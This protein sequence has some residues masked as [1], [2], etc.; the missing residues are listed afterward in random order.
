[1][2]DAFV[3][4]RSDT[5]TMPTQ[6]MLEAMVSAPLG[7]DVLGDEPTVIALQEKVA[8]LLGKEASCFVPSGTMANLTAIKSLTQ[9]GDEIIAEAGSH[10]F[11]YESGAFAAVAG[12]S[13]NLIPG[14]RGMITPEEIEQH[15]RPRNVHFPPSRLLCLENTHNAG[16]GAVWP[17]DK[18]KAVT[19]KARELGL[20][21]HL[22]GARLMNA[23]VKTGV[24]PREY[25]ELFDTVSMCFSKGLGAP[26]GSIVAGDK[27]TIRRVHRFRK[28]FGGAMRQSGILAAAAIYALDHHVHRLAE[29]HANATRLA[30]S[31]A[32]IPFLQL[33]PENVETNIIY[34]SLDSARMTAAELVRKLEQKGIRMLA[35]G[36]QTLR[37]VTHLGI[38]E[39]DIERTITEVK[40]VLK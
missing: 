39:K 10:F 22:D 6:P 29:D 7:D 34:F 15:L 28:M 32:E 5:V 17:L 2:P 18:I 25:A 31:F 40:A 21:C 30:E 4:L 26:V 9:P 33:E 23:S 36:R 13:V 27:E 14:N 12:C 24:S 37:A 35:V 3:D 16:G 1:M 8:R 19:S 38:D 20:R 11:R